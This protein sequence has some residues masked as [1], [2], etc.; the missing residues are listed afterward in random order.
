[1]DNI[2]K[3][4]TRTILSQEN[5]DIIEQDFILCCIV[6]WSLMDNIA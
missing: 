4:F 5:W 6:V 3:G 1:M 2:A